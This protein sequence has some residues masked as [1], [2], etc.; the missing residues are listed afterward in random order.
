MEWGTRYQCIGHADIYLEAVSR[1]DK[2]YMVGSSVARLSR[3]KSEVK[4]P[5]L[6]GRGEK[7]RCLGSGR[8][9]S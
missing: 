3:E 7:I 2:N 5:G 4:E 9:V 8:E 6:R 1:D